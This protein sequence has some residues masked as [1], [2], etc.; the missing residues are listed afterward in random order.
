MAYILIVDDEPS[1]CEFVQ[2]VLTDAGYDTR[3]AY[4]GPAALRLVAEVGYP[5]VLLTDVKMPRMAGDELAARLR[6]GK[7][8]LSVVYLTGFSD[9]LFRLRDE[10]ADREQLLEKPCCIKGLLRA[11]EASLSGQ[12]APIGE[13]PASPRLSSPRLSSWRDV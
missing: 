12:P 6:D 3:V 4:G 5:D 8:D 7:P 13:L 10:L 9:D 11:V 1:I 2:L